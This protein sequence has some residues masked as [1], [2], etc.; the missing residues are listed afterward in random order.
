[1][2]EVELRLAPMREEPDVLVQVLLR[3]SNR[4]RGHFRSLSFFGKFPKP[5]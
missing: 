2:D 4:T 1:M 3:V 5:Y